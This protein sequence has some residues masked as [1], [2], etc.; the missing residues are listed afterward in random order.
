MDNDA[1][2]LVAV[3]VSQIDAIRHLHEIELQG[4]YDRFNEDKIKC[5]SDSF[6][7]I[8]AAQK[9]LRKKIELL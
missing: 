8:E 5:I 3:I 1:I 2:D 7:T 6:K 4:L 9:A